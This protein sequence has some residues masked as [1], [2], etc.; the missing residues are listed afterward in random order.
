VKIAKEYMDKVD[1]EEEMQYLL[2]EQDIDYRDSL[3]VIYDFEVVELLE[4]PYAQKIVNTIW[5]SKYN[6]SASIF[7]ASSCHNLLFNYNHCRY[8]M[9]KKHRFYKKKDLEQF[10]IHIF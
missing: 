5:E 8:D 2:L 7:S 3:N 6:V 9:E 4:N 1:N 10:G